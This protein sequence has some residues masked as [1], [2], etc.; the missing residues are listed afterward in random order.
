MTDPGGFSVDSEVKSLWII[1]FRRYVGNC[2]CNRGFVSPMCKALFGRERQNKI[3]PALD[4]ISN[5]FVEIRERRRLRIIHKKPRRSICVFDDDPEELRQVDEEEVDER[6]SIVLF[7][8]HGVG[9]SASIWDEQINYF[10]RQGYEVV[11]PDL[12]GHGFS[13][14][15]RNNSE[16]EFVQLAEDMLAVFDKYHKKKNVLVGH[17]YGSSFCTVISKQRGHLISK[18]ILISG[19]GPIPLQPQ[20]C[21]LFGMP[22]CLLGCLQPCLLC[23]FRRMAFHPR[24]PK[25]VYRKSRPFKVPSYVLRAT[26]NGQNWMEGDEEY[27]KD[28]MVPVLLVYGLLDKFVNL[29]EEE[30][31][32]E[33][34]FGSKL[35]L[36]PDA[37][38]MVMLECP[39]RLNE[40]ITSFLHRD[41]STRSSIQMRKISQAEFDSQMTLRN[42]SQVSL[43]QNGE[44]PSHSNHLSPV[45]SP[46]PGQSS[47]GPESPRPGSSRIFKYKTK[48]MV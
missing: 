1:V 39:A 44:V 33:T 37:G 13:D 38:H 31:M 4:D 47:G 11:A 14:A 24:T 35:E 42:T 41:I 34:I 40:L 27:H 45:Q 43:Q 48:V 23:T 6:D 18:L 26:M 10:T 20:S 22:V 8:I 15:P 5:R 19:G 17:S 3:S 28:L 25:E 16:Y 12:L 46:K 32:E 29:D 36:V 2:M 21:H 30:W 9:G 7:F